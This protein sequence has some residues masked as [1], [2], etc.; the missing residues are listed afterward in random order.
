MGAPAQRFLS[1]LFNVGW[2]RIPS[3]VVSDVEGRP[4]LWYPLRADRAAHQRAR[5]P[6][7]C[8]LAGHP[9]VATLVKAK[10]ALRWSP[11]QIAGWLSATYDA[12]DELRVSPE[13]IYRTLFV[14]VPRR[15]AP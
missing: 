12:G 9:R 7:E 3:H 11:Q 2:H 6:K 15:A 10:L 8:R 4:P 13:T 1:E 14:G 5:R